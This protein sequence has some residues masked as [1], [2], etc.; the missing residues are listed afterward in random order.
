MKKLGGRRLISD[1]YRLQAIATDSDGKKS[2]PQSVTFR[3][4]GH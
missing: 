3:V 4:V 1:L 2:R